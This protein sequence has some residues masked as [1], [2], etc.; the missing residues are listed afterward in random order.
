V[1]H[2]LVTNDFPPKVGGIQSYLWELWRRLPPEEFV[3]LTTPYDGAAEWDRAQPFTVV[4]SR[5]PVLLPTPSLRHRIDRLADETGSEVVVLDPALPLGHLGPALRHR[6]AVVVHGAE[7]TVPGRLPG[8]R[9]LLGR[10]LRG[11]ELVVSAGEYAAAEAAYAARHDLPT[12]VVPPGVDVDRF[13]PLSPADR[14]AARTRLGLPTDVPLVVGLSRLVPRKGFDVLVAAADRLFTTGRSLAVA[15]AG[16]GRDERRLRRL[17]E[18]ASVPVHF[19]GRVPDAD[20]P[21][22]YGC[23]DVFAMCCRDRWNGLEQEGFGIVFVEAAAA[24][25][26]QLAGDS[27]GAA[28]AV[29]DGETGVVVAHPEDPEAVAIALARLLD[30]PELRCRLGRAARQRAEREFT[31]DLLA[32]RLGAGLRAL[33]SS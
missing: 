15:I 32:A 29:R 4:R 1:R 8:T 33:A 17:A 18:D 14:A 28:E 30:D 22:V 25:V 16:A 19:L 20:L 23:G 9:A 2:L 24:G 27:G 13:V 11:A 10:V 26:A 6:Y 12:L 31:Y 7:V 5:E 3:V 21:A